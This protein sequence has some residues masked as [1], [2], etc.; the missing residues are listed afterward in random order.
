M[1]GIK[2]IR[3]PIQQTNGEKEEMEEDEE[4]EAKIGGGIYKIRF[5]FG[6]N[7]LTTYFRFT[8]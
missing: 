5:K 3:S 4:K 7:F 1:H 2:E 6:A 8:V